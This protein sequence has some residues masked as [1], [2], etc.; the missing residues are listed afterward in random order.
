MGIQ[1]FPLVL[2]PII[3]QGF[4]LEEFE[5]SLRANLVYRAIAEQDAFPVRKGETVTRTRTALRPA[6]TTPLVPNTNTNFDNGLTPTSPGVEQ[7][8]LTVSA[9]ADTVDLNTKTEK[10]GIA[11]QFLKNARDLAEQAGRSIDLLAANALLSASL[12]GNTRV[13]LT[14]GAAATTISVDDIRG[15]LVTFANG[16]QVPVSATNTLAV[17]VNGNPY[18]LVGATADGGNVSTAPGGISGTLTFSANVTVAD[19]TVA[20]PVVS[21]IA[22][23]VVRPSGR[24]TTAALVPT[25]TM[26]WISCVQQSV[27][28]LRLNAVPDNDGIYNCY[29]D[30]QQL[31][32]LW[33]DTTFQNA[34]RGAHA[35]PAYKNAV[36]SIQGGVRFIPTTLAPQQT[37]GGVRVRRALVVGKGALIEGNFPTDTSDTENPLAE[38]H[39]VD[40]VTFVT[41]APM[42]RLQQIIAQSWEWIGGFTAPSDT[43]ANPT[44]IPTASNAAYKRAVVIESA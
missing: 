39:V 44:V 11:S 7:Y 19:G 3:Q 33:N 37:L 17:S 25:D 38:V 35:D 20:N 8:T 16:V 5:N 18:T 42:D 24:L 15:F 23:S 1:N 40:G 21:G 34:F 9:F 43:T 10:V 32:G 27:A 36:I 28:T 2:Q 4:L 12:G 22:P 26:A 31:L 29:L 30:A 13:R 6:V 41:R 14:L